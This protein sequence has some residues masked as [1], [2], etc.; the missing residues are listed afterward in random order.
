M[1]PK[2][3]PDLID[4]FLYS[5]EGDLVLF[6]Q[7]LGYRAFG[8][9]EHCACDCLKEVVVLMILIFGKVDC[10]VERIGVG[11]QINGFGNDCSHKN[12]LHLPHQSLLLNQVL[13][14]LVDLFSQL[15]SHKIVF[16]V[17]LLHE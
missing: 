12:N 4:I 7:A 13:P 14:A 5:R 9:V 2:I 8:L 17:K 3:A 16:G 1:S 11:E 15:S 6:D 10:L